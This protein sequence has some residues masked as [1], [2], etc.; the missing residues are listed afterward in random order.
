MLHAIIK[1]CS[2]KAILIRKNARCSVLLC[3]CYRFPL[4]LLSFIDIIE[5]K[6]F[7]M[8]MNFK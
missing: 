3:S 5:V 8:I 4:D 2:K 7:Y 1:M 6:W